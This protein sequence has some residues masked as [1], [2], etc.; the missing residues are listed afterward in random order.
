MQITRGARFNRF[1]RPPF[2]W[3][4]FIVLYAVCQI[5]CAHQPPIEKKCIEHRAA[6]DIGSATMK[7]KIATIDRCQNRNLGVVHKKDVKVPFAENIHNHLLSEN[8]QNSGIEQL[9]ALQREALAQG[10]QT[11]SGVATAAFR[12]ADNAEPYLTRIKNQ[13]GITIKLIS[14][15]EEAVLGYKAVMAGMETPSK[16]S[17]VWDIGGYSM[18][19]VMKNKNEDYVVY[20][21]KMASLSFKNQVIEKIHRGS[22]G[23]PISPNPI[24]RKNLAAVLQLAM[25]AA[26]DVP[27]EIKSYL[28]ETGISVIGIGGVHNH[29]IKKQV[30]ADDWFTR[31]DLMEALNHRIEWT[32]A[33]IGGRYANTDVSNLILVLGFMKKLDID[34]VYLKD[35]NLTDGI[36]IEPSFWQ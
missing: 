3:L 30:N 19:M 2:Y 8:I 15:D 35:V 10:A 7:M 5:G 29:S 1:V 12:E 17:L 25:T 16:N 6:F 4:V 22:A 27:D 18:Q 36:L 34:R 32:D 23:G 21:G 11:F 20:R 9:M 13:T 31:N 14:H 26:E 28:R 24:G 33:E